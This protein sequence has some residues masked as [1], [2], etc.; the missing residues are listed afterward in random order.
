MVWKVVLYIAT[1]GISVF[2][3]SA[4]AWICALIVQTFGG[5]GWA[6]F[7]SDWTLWIL[8]LSSPLI[9]VAMLRELKARGRL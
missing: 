7:H 6:F 4:L 1:F 9:F 8:G 3:A 5:N 2:A